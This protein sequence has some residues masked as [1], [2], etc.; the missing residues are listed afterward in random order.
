MGCTDFAQLYSTEFYND[1]TIAKIAICL[2]NIF[3]NRCETYCG[4]QQMSSILHCQCRHAFI[5]WILWWRHQMET[6][7][8][9]LAICAGNSPVNGEFPPQRPVTRSFDVSLICARINGWVNNREAGDLRHNYAHYGVTV[10]DMHSFVE[11]IHVPLRNVVACP[12]TLPRTRG[13]LYFL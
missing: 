8:A 1:L 12:L 7:S 5:C 3:G 9:S 2:D 11:F 6:V 10:R 13:L 4:I